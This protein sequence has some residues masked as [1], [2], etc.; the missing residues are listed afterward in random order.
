MRIP[1][2]YCGERSNDEFQIMGAA[3][4]LLARPAD[5]TQPAFDAY[6]H[7]RDN[8]AGAHRELW[9]HHGGCRH[10]LVVTRDT[11]THAVSGAVLARQRTGSAA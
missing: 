6:L 9:Y 5:A 10:W 4:A 2:P 11:H 8:P 1:C 7:A 3:D